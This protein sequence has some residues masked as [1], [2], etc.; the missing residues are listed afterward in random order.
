VSINIF[1]AYKYQKI[2]PKVHLNECRFIALFLQVWFPFNP[3]FGDAIRS[4]ATM[5]TQLS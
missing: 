2:I 5:I 4:S 3:Y 1:F